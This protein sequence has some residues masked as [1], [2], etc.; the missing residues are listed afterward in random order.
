MLG[1]DAGGER[2]LGPVQELDL[3]RGPEVLRER[4]VE[5]LS[6]TPGRGGDPG[7]DEALGEPQR[8]VLGALVAVEDQLPGAYVAGAQRVVER[9]ARRK[10]ALL[11]LESHDQ[12]SQLEIAI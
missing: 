9:G 10:Q 5:A 7:I 6:G 11:D 3:D 8:R 1:V 12:P 2:G 4:V